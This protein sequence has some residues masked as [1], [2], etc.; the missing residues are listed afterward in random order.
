MVDLQILNKM[1]DTGS[2]R[3]VLNNGLT[4]DHF[5]KYS[6]EYAMIKHHYDTYGNVPDSTTFLAK[7]PDFEKLEVNESD[8][9]LVSAIK[10]E[11]LY[12]KA[13]PVI[14]ETANLMQQD[15]NAAMAYFFSQLP[16]LQ[17]EYGVTGVDIMAESR[18]RLDEFLNRADNPDKA[19]ITTG[20]DEIDAISGKWGRGDEL[21]V[22]YARLGQGK[23]WIILTSATRAWEAGYRVG[24]IS[25][26]MTPLKIGYRVDTLVS[27]ISN[28]SL[29]RGDVNG[30]DFEKYSAHIAG[31]GKK[32]GFIVAIP[33][34]FGREVTATKLASFVKHNNLD[35]LFIDGIT[36]LADERKRRGDNLAVA[37]SNISADLKLCS[38][39]LK[40]P[41]IIVAQSNRNG[42][43][44][45]AEESTPDIDTISHSDGIAQAAT[46]VYSL[47][48]NK[49]CIMIEEKKNRDSESCAKL[50]YFWDIDHGEFKYIPADSDAVPGQIKQAVIDKSK[51]KFKTG[52][53]V[54]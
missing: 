13:T 21:A 49:S 27:H 52:S 50:N 40:I 43:Q 22:F 19:F 28:R 25:P 17:P 36:Y 4:E 10:E 7:F 54:F 14:Q 15:A 2:F 47:R 9:Y 29:V 18:D 38:I 3:L 35:I 34:D 39:D 45:D 1:I 51:E 16:D 42:V 8:D 12:A 44:R 53:D 24:F 32:D 31:L 20:F 26:E 6:E 37:L 41:I 33:S 48:Q 23:S 5:V 46:R 30:V 11:Y